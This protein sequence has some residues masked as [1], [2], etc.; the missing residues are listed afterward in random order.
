MQRRL[1][2][3]LAAWAAAAAHWLAWAYLLEFRGA[4]VHLGVWAA[5]LAFMA[6]NMV[7]LC[8][9]AGAV[10]RPEAA[11]DAAE[12]GKGCKPSTLQAA[13]RPIEAG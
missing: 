7:L 13:R 2:V 10:A 4:P 6:A 9:L 3:A 8:A 1:L 12:S 11:D 5:G